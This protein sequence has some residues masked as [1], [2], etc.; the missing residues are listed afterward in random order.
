MENT[1]VNKDQEKIRDYF[2]EGYFCYPALMDITYNLQATLLLSVMLDIEVQLEMPRFSITNKAL[3]EI[4][5]I[6]E[7]K[8]GE[9]KKRLNEFGLIKYSLEKQSRRTYYEIDSSEIRKKLRL[10]RGEKS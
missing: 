4:T 8:V 1:N 6:S 9:A 7:G 5:G 10:A 3:H 2:S